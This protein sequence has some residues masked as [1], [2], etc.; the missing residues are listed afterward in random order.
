M[1]TNFKLNTKDFNTIQALYNTMCYMESE[2]TDLE[3]YFRKVDKARGVRYDDIFTLL[4]K[5]IDSNKN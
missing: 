2:T 4:E 1:E 5:I 3:D